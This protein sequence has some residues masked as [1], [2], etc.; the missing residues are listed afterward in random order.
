MTKPP[1]FELFTDGACLGNPG[2]G[3]WAYILRDSTGNEVVASG[4]DPHTTN[5]KM[6]VTAVLRALESLEEPSVVAIHADSQYVT[7]GLTQWMDGWIAKGWKNA[8][9]KS[10]ANQDLWKPLSELRKKHT[11]TTSWVKG[12]S[13][14]PEN[15]RCDTIASAEAEKLLQ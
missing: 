2:P 3:G 14:H 5:Q 7:K 1:T 6:E 8:S 11:I 13:G 12:H 4:G 9:K 15:E 10:V